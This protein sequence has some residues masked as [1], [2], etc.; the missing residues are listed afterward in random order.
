M[1]KDIENKER[2]DRNIDLCILYI[3]KLNI[4]KEIIMAKKTI[5]YIG[6]DVGN[7]D[8]KS[9]NTTLPSGYEGPYSSKPMLG[10]ECLCL[11][12]QYYQI[13][14]DRLFYMQD[15]TKNERCIVLTLCSIASEILNKITKAKKDLD[16]QA[17]QDYI[18]R[19]KHIALGAG[20]PIA[21]YRKKDVQAL[22]AYYQGYMADGIS[23]DYNDFHFEFK[24]DLCK[25][26]PQ[27]GAAAAGISST[28]FSTY[29]T[30]YIIDIG[31]YTLDIAQFSNGSPQKDVHSM[32]LGIIILYDSIVDKIFKDYDL[33][34]DYGVIEDVLCGRPHVIASNVVE[35]IR[36]MTKRHADKI[37]YALRQAKVSFSS[38]PCIFVGGGSI[39][40]KKY[41]LENPLIR[42]D[43]VQFVTDTRANAKG[44]AK[45][46]RSSV[47]A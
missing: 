15:K 44:Y 24:M 4:E 13:T 3:Y 40:L 42:H 28:I 8:T 33:S 47:V 27:G 46:L 43:I 9:Q 35:V 6:V 22:T 20:L 1:K 5:M 45:L 16:H 25:I 11:D 19:V 36:D 41:I 26:Y 7:F 17:I 12:G 38:Y 31:G 21:H 18:D 23:F 37:I 2:V 14:S 39:V 30:Y 32:E 10:R 29:P 34:I